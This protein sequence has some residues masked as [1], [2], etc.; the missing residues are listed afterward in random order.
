M[1]FHLRASESVPEG[2]RRIA[3]DQLRR[4]IGEIDD[5]SLSEDKT[6]HQ[7]RKRC[8]KLRGLIR[9]VRPALGKQYGTANQLFRDA[10]REV[11]G[12]RDAQVL[13]NTYDKLM[14]HFTDQV[15]RPAFATVRRELTMRLKALESQPAVSPLLELRER[16]E[17]AITLVDSWELDDKG[18][19]AIAA[20]VSKTHQRARDCLQ[21]VLVQ[22]NTDALH[23]LRKRIK[24]LSF[25]FRLLRQSWPAAS[26]ALI[27]TLKSIEDI[28]GEDH[29]LAMLDQALAKEPNEF[30]DPQDVQ[31]FRALI[32]TRRKQH[33]EKAIQQSRFVLAEETS[34]LTERFHA[35]WRIWRKKAAH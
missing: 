14:E 5:D 19:S 3:I 10:A 33:Q 18:F 17:Q 23:Q 11:S 24:Y 35:Y 25:Q 4:A 2:V 28:L 22:P 15:N 13:I 30:G 31:A 34:A 1:A 26:D 16:F 29:D 32:A 12:L 6:V 27:E 7:I 8:K 21:E 20:G 9:L